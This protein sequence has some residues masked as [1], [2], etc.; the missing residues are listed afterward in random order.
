MSALNYGFSG[1]MVRGSGVPWDLRKINSYKIYKN[2]NFSIPVGIH[3]D[4]YD[5][6][7]LRMDEM[8]QR[9]KIIF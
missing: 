4:C 2:L 1:V 9:L 8:R 7:L 5:R 3:G 6:Y